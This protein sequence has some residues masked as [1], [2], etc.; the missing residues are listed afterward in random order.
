MDDNIY[1]NQFCFV[2]SS[3]IIRNYVINYDII[4]RHKVSSMSDTKA[5]SPAT[6]ANCKFNR[7]IHRIKVKCSN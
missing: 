5:N 3:I 2:D 6:D 4:A 7:C 1:E